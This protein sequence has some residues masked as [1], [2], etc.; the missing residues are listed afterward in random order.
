MLSSDVLTLTCTSVA[1][2]V[3]KVTEVTSMQGPSPALVRLALLAVSL[4]AAA[5]TLDTSYPDAVV[6]RSDGI[7]VGF[8]SCNRQQRPNPFWALMDE[9]DAMRP[10]VF[11]WLGDIVYADRLVAPLWRVPA[12]PQEITDAYAVCVCVCGWCSVVTGAI[13]VLC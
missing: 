5:A 4:A 2:K 7:R 8:G 6:N 11:V 13:D 1:L 3:S 10:D 12:T 9:R